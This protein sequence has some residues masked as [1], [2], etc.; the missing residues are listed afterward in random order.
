M[1]TVFDKDEHK[2][3]IYCDII[4]LSFLFLKLCNGKTFYIYL[5]I[6]IKSKT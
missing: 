5:F 4:L 6:V 2:V 3:F 1:R